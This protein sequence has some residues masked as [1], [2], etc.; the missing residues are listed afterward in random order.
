MKKVNEKGFT[1]A[2][3]LI[4][5]AILAV[6]VAVAIPVFT[7]QLEKA[8]ESTDVANV[9]DAYAEISVAM[10]DGSLTNTND[11]IKILGTKE[12]KLKITAGSPAVE[13]NPENNIEAAD[14][15][16]AKKEV[17][18]TGFVHQQKVFNAWSIGTPNIA[19][20]NLTA[21]TASTATTLT[22]TFTEEINSSTGSSH[23]YL[24]A[25]AFS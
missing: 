6:L 5:V 19:G 2:E 8:R 18:V 25:V 7:E 16:P 20:I 14:A 21:P 17:A 23:Y 4:V 3:L 10:A 11:I 22:F 1:L 24:S 9:R 12:A 13:A 15:V